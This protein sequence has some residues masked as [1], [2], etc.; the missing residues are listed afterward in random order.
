MTVRSV[1][2]DSVVASGRTAADGTFVA[3]LVPGGYR[4]S[5]DTG[6]PLPRCEP[7]DLTVLDR[8]VA[9]DIACDTGIR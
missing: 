2:D 1:T 4:V 8:D 6:G 7:V 3:E 5:V 9:A